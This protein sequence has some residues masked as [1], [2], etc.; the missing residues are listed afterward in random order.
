MNALSRTTILLMVATLL[1]AALALSAGRA[2]TAAPGVVVEPEILAQMR[3]QGQA[4]YMIFLSARPDLS[5]AYEMDWTERGRHVVEALQ[6]T[7]TRSQANVRDYLER[8][9]IDY[10]TFWIDNIIVVES[11]DRA[12]LE[13]LMT[14]S[15]IQSLRA[16]RTMSL[17]EPMAGQNRVSP[18]SVEDNLSHIRADQVWE[19]GI[20]GAGVVVANID[21]GVR[22]T[23]ETLMPHYRGNLGGGAFDHDYNW[24][25]PADSDAVPTD[26]H[27]HGTHTMGTMIGDDDG[28]NQIGMAPGA[29]WIACDGCAGG[30]CPGAALLTCA[31][32]IAAPYPIGD[33]GAADADKRP[34]VVNNSW[35]DCGT[36]YSGW[37]QASVDSWVAAG[38]Y[39]VF[40]NGNASNC[41]Y[42]YP[43][44]LNTVG[45][46]ARY[47]NVT[48]VGSTGLNNGEYATHSNWGPTDREDTLNP[49]GFPYL[50]P[51]VVAPGVNIRSSYGG[52]D[53]SYAALSGTS[54]SAPHV[55]GLVAL[56]WQAA[57]CLLGDYAT[58]ET[59]IEQTAS[60]IAYATGNGDEGPGD[61]PNHATGWGEIDALTAVEEATGRCEGTVHLK[62]EALQTARGPGQT[63]IYTLS[64]T[65]TGVGAVSNIILTDTLP[66]EQRVLSSA[67]SAGDC[68]TI[69]TPTWGGGITCTLGTLEVGAT[70][71]VTLTAEV[72]TTLPAELP[73]LMRNS[74]QAAA[75][76]S[77][78]TDTADVYLH[79]C[80][81]R[82]ND[83]PQEYA[84][85]QEAVNQASNG[86]TVKISGSCSEVSEYGGSRQ[87][88]YILN[89]V[90]LQGGYS[91]GNW[92]TPDPAAHPTVLDAKG[93]G[94]VIRVGGGMSP[95]IEGLRITGG[96]AAGQGGG[97]NGGD[98]GG[99]IYVH[100]ASVTI[101]DCT[102][103][104]NQAPDEGGGLYLDSAGAIVSTNVFTGNSAGKGAGLYLSHSSATVSGNVLSS[105]SATDGGGVYL[106]HSDATLT[107]NTISRNSA[108]NGA[109]MYLYFSDP[110]LTRNE[111]L[112]NTAQGQG[113]GLALWYSHPNLINNIL[114]GN[115]A[116]GAGAGLYLHGSSPDLLH[117]TIAG[118]GSGQ[119]VAVTRL[120]TNHS[121]PS[122]AN[123]ILVG[124][125]V[126]ISVTAG[127]TAVLEGTLWGSGTWANG[128]D[129]TG[130]GTITTGAANV[131]GDPAFFYP[132]GDNYHLGPG[133]AAID[134]GVEAGVSNDIDGQARPIGTGYDVGADEALPGVMVDPATGGKLIYTDAHGHRTIIE[135][136]A[137]SVVETIALIYTPLETVTAPADYHDVGHAFELNA[138]QNGTLLP[139]YAFDLP[140]HVTIHYSASQVTGLDENL[141]VLMYWD[142]GTSEWQEGACGAYV[143]SPGADWLTIPICHVGRFALLG[144]TRVQALFTASPAWGLAP[145]TVSFANASTGSSISSRWDLGDGATSTLASPVHT[146]T[147]IGSFT[148]SLTVTG[149]AGSDTLSAPGLITVVELAW[150]YFPFVLRN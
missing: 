150:L 9:G 50:K 129:S 21:T 116:G 89:G 24:L 11:S 65:A 20:D 44:G 83:D 142:T 123:T 71:R 135:A 33:P 47:A 45:N 63:I 141:L 39:P 4:G 103:Y 109:G 70:V 127:N 94:R 68:Q 49:R 16:L 61:V 62:K 2:A 17:I 115:Q 42:S 101:R 10:V 37:F 122:L 58:T 126:G 125:A 147:E 60:P 7:A 40:S 74:A 30:G 111:L 64:I 138:Y 23:H 78:S 51:Q 146:Y 69:A 53:S 95:I 136:P 145:L 46:P 34:Q 118:D 82:I 112:R 41:S 12:T 85:V 14:F 100:Y 6:K 77:S 76:Q 144:M 75:G 117:T 113:G 96:D 87:V 140:I 56:M 54:M 99:G 86:D 149:P 43:P 29:E 57:P 128:Q 92:D 132:A 134:A 13:G 15:E 73:H 131:W 102:I 26:E 28:T 36:S 119:G 104:D 66:A 81:A 91:A 5:A 84:S 67:A 72:T 88:V 35:G 79:S 137:G 25:S 130:E 93:N 120:G 27:G 52:S 110:A 38:I 8:R 90:N 31:Q 107:L 121:N 106:S 22:Y 1:C 55:A 114:A 19:T 148:V 32:W 139:G 143:R 97:P 59:I 48:G 80:Y 108:T 133:S 105:G 3:Q 98:A 124:H 18:T